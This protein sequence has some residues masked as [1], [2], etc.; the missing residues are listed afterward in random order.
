MEEIFFLRDRVYRNFIQKFS[1]VGG[2]YDMHRATPSRGGCSPR[3]LN[4]HALRLLLV[5]SGL[6]K[7]SGDLAANE[8][9][10]HR[11]LMQVPQ[12]AGPIS[13]GCG[14]GR[15]SVLCPRGGVNALITS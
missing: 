10:V 2:K 8:L 5:A 11:V 15:D 3:K 4:L 14:V 1:R 6:P 9:H 7:S 13:M 12:W